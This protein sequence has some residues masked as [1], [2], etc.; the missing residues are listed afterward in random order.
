MRNSP[1]LLSTALA[2]SILGGCGGGGGGGGA[3]GVSPPPTT[4]GI[5]QPVAINL[6]P[7]T[8]STDSDRLFIPVTAVGTAAVSMPLAFDTGSA[9][10]TLYAL[11]IFP[12]SMVSAGGFVF[13]SGQTSIAYQ[14]ITVTNQSGTRRFGSATTGRTQ[15]GNIGYATVT[16]G[17]GGGTLM[18][19]T[20]PVFL[21][22]LIT[23]N[24][25]GQSEPVPH[26][27]GWF[28]VN[29]APN[30]ITITGSLEPVTGF[31]GC[32]AGTAGSCYVASVLKY[33]T[34]GAGVNAGFMLS[35]AALQSC[36]I[37]A[38]GDCAP[39]PMLTVGLNDTVKSGFSTVK[40][41]C[42]PS[43]YLGPAMIDG[44]AVC[45]AGIPNT[46]IT[47]SGS[48]SGMLAGPVLFDSGTPSMVLNVPGAA[49]FPASVPP[50]NTVLVQTASGFTFSYTAG[51]GSEVTNTVVQQNS[52]AE[53][54]IGIGYFTT[55]S[56][57]IDF[58]AG[59]EGWK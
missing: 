16:F 31:P 35:P 15:T 20:M 41:T 45:Q 11:D 40:L 34:Y 4:S 27:R 18:T 22:Y 36:D 43:N 39:S 25:T 56:F 54:I 42:P 33:L 48:A 37:T 6:Y 59:T 49:V 10:I 14:G 50:G 21:Y 17:D 24:S 13:A 32:A 28:G 51:T 58:T 7:E 46:L 1:Y 53:S 19:T 23:D 57:F 55:N 5:S 29:D 8:S 52:A 44:Y 30:L 38:P 12:A 47:V 26:Q 3:Q 9:G 2:A